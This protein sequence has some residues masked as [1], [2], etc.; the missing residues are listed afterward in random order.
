MI[1]DI[2]WCDD[3]EPRFG[4]WLVP[5]FTEPRYVRP[6]S[7]HIGFYHGMQKCVNNT[8][9][10]PY[11]SS[12]NL[13]TQ[14]TRIG[15]ISLSMNGDDGVFNIYHQEFKEW[16]NKNKKAIPAVMQL[17]EIALKNLNF[18]KKKN[19]LGVNFYV[20]KI[21]ASLKMYTIDLAEVDLLEA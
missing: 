9:Q 5:V 13:D 17:D 11:V 2:Y 21:L 14:G 20:E 1:L 7:A 8:D 4:T 10:Y 6:K 16:I 19:I 12:H 3:Q 18:K 15:N